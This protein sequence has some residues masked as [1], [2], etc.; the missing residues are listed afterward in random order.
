VSF[1]LVY[2][3]MMNTNWGILPINPTLGQ[4]RSQIEYAFSGS[5]SIGLWGCKRDLGAEEVLTVDIPGVTTIG[6]DARTRAISQVNLFWHH[7]FCS[8][9]DSYLW[10]GIPDH[11]R[12]DEDGSVADWAIGA[13]VQAP[14]T[15]ALALYANASY[16][17]PSAAAGVQGAIDA[18]WD[19]GMGVV[20]YFGRHAVSH[21][22]NGD[23]WEPY[24]AVANNS[25]FLVEQG[26][27]V[28]VP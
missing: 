16:L 8:G 7:K 4:W 6:L 15:D 13:N 3:W 2:D 18:G 21:S 12:F 22:I 11:G 14:L 17:H 28:T 1:G 24:M 26:L 23:C 9:A 25:T 20:W 19:V 5:N 10:A 27:G